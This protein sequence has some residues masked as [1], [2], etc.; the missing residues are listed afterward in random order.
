MAMQKITLG[1]VAAIAITALLVSVLGALMATQTF[2]NTATI[3]TAGIGVYSDTGFTQKVTSLD[4]GTLTPGE[5]KAKTLYIRNE[6]STQISLSMSVGNWTPPST[7]DYI[8]VIWNRQGTILNVG[9]STSAMFTLSVSQSIT[10]I[11]SFTFDIT[12]TGTEHT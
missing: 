1:T 10:G 2:N 6:G 11:T 3:K 12:I 4:W 8:T 5:T 7:S 9:S